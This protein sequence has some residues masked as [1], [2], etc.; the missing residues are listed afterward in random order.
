[1]G[2]IE[3]QPVRPAGGRAHLDEASE[4]GAEELGPIGEGNAEEAD[5][6]VGRGIP[7]D[8]RI[9]SSLGTLWRSPRTT[10]SSNSS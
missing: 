9:S 10:P 1:M 2:F 7:E 8:L 6:E 4:D 3:D 5:R